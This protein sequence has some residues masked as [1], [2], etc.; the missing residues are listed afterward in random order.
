MTVSFL[1]KSGDLGRWL[2]DGNLEFL[3]RIDYQIKIN[4]N[5]V[6][7]GEIENSIQQMQGMCRVLVLPVVSEGPRL[8]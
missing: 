1:Y 3:G 5:R 8:S 2:P 6:E 7:P 4:G